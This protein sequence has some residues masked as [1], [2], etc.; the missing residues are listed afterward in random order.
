M[1]YRT[2]R[3][4]WMLSLLVSPAWPVVYS[5]K[6]GQTAKDVQSLATDIGKGKQ[7]I[8]DCPTIHHPDRGLNLLETLQSFTKNE[9]PGAC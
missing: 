3:F 2:Y 8:S 4:A 5:P 6:V 1:H 9:V 7:L